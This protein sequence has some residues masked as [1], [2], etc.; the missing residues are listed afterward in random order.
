MGEQ[1]MRCTCGH[2]KT[3]HYQI[4]AAGTTSSCYEKGCSCKVYTPVS[5]RPKPSL[6]PSW[7]EYF[8]GIARQAASRATCKRKQ[9]GAVL[10]RDRAILSTG[11]NGSVRGLPHCIDDGCVMEDGHC[12]ATVHAEANAIAQAAKH[13]AR[14]DGATC[15]VTASP[16]WGCAKLLLNAGVIRVV[17]GEE[18][19]LDQKVVQA[20]T[21]VG[22]NLELV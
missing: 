14:I 16:C 3:K 20:F 7:D 10:V 21:N 17:Y 2:L 18:Y 11:Y 9:V 13:G 1:T 8:V 6:R 19:R 12:V 22:A 5:E 4:S 15:Y